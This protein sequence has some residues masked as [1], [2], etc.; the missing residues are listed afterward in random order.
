MLRRRPLGKKNS[1]SRK[2]NVM[3]SSST[4]EWKQNTATW[5]RDGGTVRV[6][7]TVNCPPKGQTASLPTLPRGPSPV[8]SAFHRH[9]SVTSPWITAGCE[10]ASSISAFIT[11][12]GTHPLHLPGGLTSGFSRSWEDM[13]LNVRDKLRLKEGFAFFI[14]PSRRRQSAGMLLCTS[15]AALSSPSQSK[16]SLL[17]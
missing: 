6:G 14:P 12:R 4:A 16:Q 10:G 5:W 13:F 11:G 17:Q 3:S 1:N 9:G 15:V 2:G 8:S 7:G